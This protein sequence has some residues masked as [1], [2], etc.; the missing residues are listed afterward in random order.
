MI[1][2]HAAE[3]L[4]ITG[5]G[6]LAV[7]DTPC[8]DLP[9]LK[10]QVVLID[11]EKYLVRGVEYTHPRK[12]SDSFGLLVHPSLTGG[13][14]LGVLDGS[15]SDEELPVISYVP[16]KKPRRISNGMYPGPGKSVVLVAE[17]EQAA[18]RISK[19]LEVLI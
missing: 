1:E 17:Y 6:T 7:I 16:V 11:G 8:D 4:T 3:W 13:I 15:A 14:L 10:N 12:P 5:R 18:L 19:A 2:L 9:S